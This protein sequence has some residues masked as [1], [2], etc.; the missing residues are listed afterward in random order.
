MS[1]TSS[2]SGKIGQLGV[3]FHRNAFAMVSAELE[4]PKESSVE[5]VST[6]RDPDTGVSIRFIRAWDNRSSKMTN[7]FD[8]MIGFGNF[9]NDA[10]AVA[11]ACG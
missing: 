1:G 11:V 4:T 10:C 2:P 8:V 3:A 5:L 7:R 6:M 9:Y